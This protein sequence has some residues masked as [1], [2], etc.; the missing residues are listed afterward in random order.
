MPDSADAASNIKPACGI[1][2]RWPDDY[3]KLW[4]KA[5]AYHNKSPEKNMAAD[6][7]KNY[8]EI[9]KLALKIKD[10]QSL[11]IIQGYE[12]YWG[13]LESDY[14]HNGGKQPTGTDSPSTKV[15]SMVMQL[16]KGIK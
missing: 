1:V 16:C 13:Q 14:S 7:M 10:K 12:V 3:V 5:I 11:N 4:P 2:Q 6:Y 15:L 8:I 9:A